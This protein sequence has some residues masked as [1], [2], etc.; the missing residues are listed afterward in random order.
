LTQERQKYALKSI[1][2]NNYLSIYKFRI[3]HKHGEVSA[4]KQNIGRRG[5]RYFKDVFTSIIDSQWRWTFLIFLC[6][7]L[8][9][10]TSFAVFWYLMALAS[11]DLGY[12]E[13]WLN[14]HNQEQYERDNPHTP[15][16]RHL[17]SFVS[18]FLFSIETQHTIGE[19][20]N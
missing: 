5:K 9:T 4:V 7:F 10:W 6:G 19:R 16:V 18:A 1:T 20:V 15:C 3:V 8:V 14:A 12:Y 2:T 13:G 17:Y 11:G